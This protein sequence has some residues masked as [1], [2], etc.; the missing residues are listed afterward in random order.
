MVILLCGRS[1]LALGRGEKAYFNGLTSFP[2][3]WW[4]LQSL[5][6][7]FQVVLPCSS[8]FFCAVTRSGLLFF[9]N[10]ASYTILILL[11]CGAYLAKPRPTAIRCY[12]NVQLHHVLNNAYFILRVLKYIFISKG[13]KLNGIPS[14]CEVAQALGQVLEP[15]SLELCR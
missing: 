4:L 10:I 13:G 7:N 2:N 5:L 1:P 15:P 11:L 3:L 9:L 12:K 8:H 14:S 6:L